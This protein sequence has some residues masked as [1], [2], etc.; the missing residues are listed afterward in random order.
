MLTTWLAHPVLLLTLLA[1]PVGM[2]LLLYAHFRRQRID[3]PAGQPFAPGKTVVVRPRMRFAKTLCVLTGIA[4]LGLAS[5]G[6]R[7]G[8]DPDAQHRKGTT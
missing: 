7:W 6:P 5:A 4:L 3:G 2:A 8:L 1:V